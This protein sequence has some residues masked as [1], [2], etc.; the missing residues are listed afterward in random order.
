MLRATLM[1]VATSVVFLLV[2]NEILFH[3]VVEKD[4]SIFPSTV[5][6][7]AH[8]VVMIIS[9]GL[10]FDKAFQ[11]WSD[12]NEVLMPN[13]QQIVAKD[14]ASFCAASFSQAPT[15]SRACHTAMLAGFWEDM[16]NIKTHW[17]R[18]LHPFD[19]VLA[20]ATNGW[21]FGGPDVVEAY[22]GPNVT[23]RSF[24]YSRY[25]TELSAR[26][27]DRWAVDQYAGILSDREAAGK[28]HARGNLFV[29][30]LAGV[31][32]NG[33][34]HGP[35]SVQYTDNAAYVDELIVEIQSLT[36]ACFHDKATVYIFTSDHGFADLGGHGTSDY[37]T[38]RCP[39]V[40]W[41]W[42]EGTS[43]KGNQRM[44][45]NARTFPQRAVHTIISTILGLPIA[46]N[47]F[48]GLPYHIFGLPSKVLAQASMAII[49]QLQALF[50]VKIERL[51]SKSAL[52]RWISPLWD[53]FGQT[54]KA[55]MFQQ[56]LEDIG[57]E[58]PAEV[59]E[60][61]QV[62]AQSYQAALISVQRFP[63]KALLLFMLIINLLLMTQTICL[64]FNYVL[65]RWRVDLFCA[66]MVLGLFLLA[67]L[68]MILVL[69]ILCPLLLISKIR[70][71]AGSAEESR[72]NRLSCLWPFL[73]T[74]ATACCV[75]VRPDSFLPNERVCFIQLMLSS[76]V[77]IMLSG[78]HLL[79]VPVIMA[80]SLK[81]LYILTANSLL[82]SISNAIF[83]LHLLILPIKSISSQ[84]LGQRMKNLGLHFAVMTV[85]SRHLLVVTGLAYAIVRFCPAKGK[86]HG[87]P[88]GSR[89][90]GTVME[91]S[92]QKCISDAVFLYAV[93]MASILLPSGFLTL[94][95]LDVKFE[96][97]PFVPCSIL[98]LSILPLV[99]KPLLVMQTLWL[100][101]GPEQ[102]ADPSRLHWIWVMLGNL[103]AQIVLIALVSWLDQ[104]GSWL[105]IGI[106]LA[107][108]IFC[109]F[110][111][112]IFGLAWAVVP[113]IQKQFVA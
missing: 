101:R 14:S 94:D 69:A 7:L 84:S 109:L 38:R 99:L 110:V 85:N 45:C 3:S 32:T 102:F 66:S 76:S 79:L 58:N 86:E 98:A 88:T 42:P 35:H 56:A 5:N 46:A 29:L 25:H 100:I 37:N 78:K 20:R 112:H 105:E 61:C 21:I 92:P 67:Q 2:T 28:L 31:D 90:E 50:S 40:S 64:P 11:G 36:E 13:L 18:N 74:I 63:G 80:I 23:I 55:A 91:M 59:L 83:M 52:L 107:K 93:L 48:E 108:Y 77:F 34:R 6:P 73:V 103:M 104:P 71:G 72:L 27:L 4:V 81:I 44:Q 30:H 12:E 57:T 54:R 43:L 9:D 22:P 39:F 15:E 96:W 8:R 97:V 82:V 53:P 16:A 26:D 33:H 65:Y 1:L 51:R 62:L 49:G 60:R 19:H 95:P 47:N 24:E 75:L 41:G 70:P 113:F 87:L 89:Q 10:R 68:E 17:R 106:G 111:G